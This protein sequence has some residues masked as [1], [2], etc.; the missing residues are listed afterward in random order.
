MVSGRK[1]K[2][3]PLPPTNLE[4]CLT[5][6]IQHFPL[7]WYYIFSASSSNA[8]FR[9]DCLRIEPCYFIRTSKFSSPKQEELNVVCNSLSVTVV[10]PVIVRLQQKCGLRKIKAVFFL[11]KI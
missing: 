5:L 10:S 1:V 2:D 4:N 7:W 3:S 8:A 9:K 6:K 11:L